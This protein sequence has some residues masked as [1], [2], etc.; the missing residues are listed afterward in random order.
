MGNA[1]CLRELSRM[2]P[3]TKKMENWH[4]SLH[5]H[6]LVIHK[7]TV[8]FIQILP[9]KLLLL[10]C[11]WEGNGWGEENTPPHFSLPPQWAVAKQTFTLIS[12]VP[13]Q[14]CCLQQRETFLFLPCP[15][16]GRHA[17]SMANWKREAANEEIQ[18]KDHLALKGFGPEVL[19]LLTCYRDS[20]QM[21]NETLQLSWYLQKHCPQLLSND[22]Q[23]LLEGSGDGQGKG[24]QSCRK[25]FR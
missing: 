1:F 10:H 14:T 25:S 20:L 11:V 22:I 8:L 21:E 15:S 6:L 3:A 17:K 23:S 16:S 18:N 4:C 2:Y 19:R 13:A 5:K 24:T 9:G 7:V 12:S